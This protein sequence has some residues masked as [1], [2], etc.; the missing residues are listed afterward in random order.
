MRDADL[1]GVDMR[2]ANLEDVSLH[3]TKMRGA[4]LHSANLKGV[5]Y[6]HNLKGVKN[7]PELSAG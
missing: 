3:G 2:G 7:L 4:D 5:K 1:R 6:R